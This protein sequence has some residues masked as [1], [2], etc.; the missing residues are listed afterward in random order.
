MSGQVNFYSAFYHLNSIK[1]AIQ[2][3]CTKTEKIK[4]MLNTH[5]IY[6]IED[7][8]LRVI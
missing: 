5:I 8:I 3:K 1:A 2:V 6:C 7:T 4:L